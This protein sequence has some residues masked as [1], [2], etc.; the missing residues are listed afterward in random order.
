MKGEP[1]MA[2]SENFKQL[3]ER[4]RDRAAEAKQMG[5]SDDDIA[6]ITTQIGDWLAREAEPRSYEQ[7]LM[8]EF[9]DVCDAEE[10]RVLS[11]ALLRVAAKESPTPVG[12]RVRGDA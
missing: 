11:K 5:L 2:F 7:R 10:K 4:L 6:A 3:L 1:V 8:K 9:W 12:A